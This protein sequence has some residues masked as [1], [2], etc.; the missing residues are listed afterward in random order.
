MMMA[1]C[2]QLVGLGQF[3]KFNEGPDGSD[4]FLPLIGLNSFSCAGGRRRGGGAVGTGE[5][6]VWGVCELGMRGG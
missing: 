1:G 5:C 4:G 3:F 6:F 2:L